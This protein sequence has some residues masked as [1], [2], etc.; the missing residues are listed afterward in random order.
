MLQTQSVV[1]TP[2]I[3]KN[4][5]PYIRHY[6]PT[7]KQILEVSREEIIMTL[8]NERDSSK[9]D[10]LLDAADLRLQQIPTPPIEAT[11]SFVDVKGNILAHKSNFDSASGASN[12][13]S[14]SIRIRKRSYF[15]RTRKEKKKKKFKPMGNQ[16]K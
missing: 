4:G 9:H 12:V 6:Y 2:V 16:A 10:D 11:D 15:S 5:L 3:F 8:K 7:G 1:F 14:T 13:S